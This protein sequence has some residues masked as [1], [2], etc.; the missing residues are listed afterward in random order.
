ML[1]TSMIIF[2]QNII[3]GGVVAIHFTNSANFG[4][5]GRRLLFSLSRRFISSGFYYADVIAMAI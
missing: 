5:P 1:F 4:H 3:I 2:G